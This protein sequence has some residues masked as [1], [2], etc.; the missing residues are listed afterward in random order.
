MRNNFVNKWLGTYAS[1]HKELLEVF[2]DT[3]TRE[4]LKDAIPLLDPM[5][6]SGSL[7]VQCEKESIASVGYDINP[8]QVIQCNAKLANASTFNWPVVRRDIAHLKVKESHK[9]IFSRNWFDEDVAKRLLQ[10]Y[11]DIT[12]YA[13]NRDGNLKRITIAAFVLSLRAN[14]CYGTSSNPTWLKKGGMVPGTNIKKAFLAAFDF[15]GKWHD[16]TY[17]KIKRKRIFGRVYQKD[18]KSIPD[19]QL[20]QLCI[21]SPPYCNR[22]DYKR[23]MAPEYYFMSRYIQQKEEDEAFIGDN[24]IHDLDLKVYQP[25]E[26]EARLLKD[27][28]S[29]QMPDDKDYYYKYYFKYLYELDIVL[30]KI[31][32]ALRKHGTLLIAVQNSHYK[33]IAINIDDIICEKIRDHHVVHAIFSKDRQ[34]FGN[35]L[36]V[37]KKQ[38]ETILRITKNG[39][40]AT[41]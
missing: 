17:G 27:I 8:V 38:R 39:N 19:R 29:R 2:R 26:Y 25:T 33:D 24:V 20:Y 12:V 1:Y 32:V 35:I 40:K 10:F 14:A 22:L 30:N 5:C 7:L 3:I 28:R 36:K 4:T 15:I 23:M 31:M 13:A 21:T 41:H 6:G 11:N 9:T 34:F 37:N 18:I 16:I